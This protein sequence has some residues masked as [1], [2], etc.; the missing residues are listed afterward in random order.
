M[1]ISEI[2]EICHEAHILAM[3]EANVDEEE[4]AIAEY[5]DDNELRAKVARYNYLLRCFEIEKIAKRTSDSELH[6]VKRTLHR[7]ILISIISPIILAVAG[8]V[9]YFGITGNINA[10]ISAL[11]GKI[12]M[13]Q[14]SVSR[15]SN[16][17][18]GLEANQDNFTNERKTSWASIPAFADLY[19]DDDL[20]QQESIDAVN[21]NTDSIDKQNRHLEER[22][23]QLDE[24]NDTLRDIEF[25]QSQE[26]ANRDLDRLLR[27]MK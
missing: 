26:N 22:N 8:G 21:R 20:K 24:L 13:V 14:S 19:S 1:N 9:L 2:D 3:A 5:S 12:S 7:I 6:E 17:V 23:R 16:K 11:G 4:I 15:I 25:N 18:S 10:K 27:N